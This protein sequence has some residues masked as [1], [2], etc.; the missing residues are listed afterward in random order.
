MPSLMINFNYRRRE[1][2]FSLIEVL[3]AMLVL[4]IGLLGLAA[5]QAQGMRFNHDAYVRTSA[6]NLASDIIDKGIILFTE[7]GIEFEPVCVN[8]VVAV[9]VDRVRVI[10]SDR[11]VEI[12]YEEDTRMLVETSDRVISALLDREVDA[13]RGRRDHCYLAGGR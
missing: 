10:A 1:R 13:T 7:L 9:E 12:L 3:V 5:L 6:T 8:D 4:A 2:G 11:P